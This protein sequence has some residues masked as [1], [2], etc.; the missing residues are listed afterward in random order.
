MRAIGRSPIEA[1]TRATTRVP[2]ST[3]TGRSST[4]WVVASQVRRDH[5]LHD[6]RSATGADDRTVGR[7]GGRG[8]GDGHGDSW[9]WVGADHAVRRRPRRATRPTT[10]ST[11]SWPTMTAHSA[12]PCR[13]VVCRSRSIRRA[14]RRGPTARSSADGVRRS[15]TRRP[16]A[17]N[18]CAAVTATFWPKSAF[19]R[20]DTPNTTAVRA[21]ARSGPSGSAAR[22]MTPRNHSSS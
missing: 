1:A 2:Q 13:P 5:G 19:A 22:R 21:A 6:P 3:P 10:N 8:R 12:P 17:P 14:W 9:V 11:T 15:R 20:C 16:R 7:S 4:R 18:A